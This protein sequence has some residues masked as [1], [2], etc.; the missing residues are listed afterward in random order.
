MQKD[1]FGIFIFLALARAAFSMD[2]F[3]PVFVSFFLLTNTIFF[4]GICLLHHYFFLKSE[5]SS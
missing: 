1:T 3:S 5:P 2:Q 4:P